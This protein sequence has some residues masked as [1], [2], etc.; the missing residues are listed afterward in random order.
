MR[1][2]HLFEFNFSNPNTHYSYA[3]L[4]PKYSKLQTA[5]DKGRNCGAAFLGTDTA[6]LHA[7]F[8]CLLPRG[9]QER[10]AAVS[11]LFYGQLS[12][13]VLVLIIVISTVLAFSSLYVGGAVVVKVRTDRLVEEERRRMVRIEPAQPA[14][15]PP[16][17]YMQSVA[18]AT[19]L[20]ERYCDYFKFFNLCL[21]IQ[22][23]HFFPG[24]NAEF[25]LISADHRLRNVA[26]AHH[27]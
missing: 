21:F 12:T 10:R 19:T 6:A 24:N 25:L 22:K 4:S 26:K 3:L 9:S 13:L 16:P 18:P 8:G 15:V 23:K 2:F 27:A 1:N 14:P 20:S 5:V 7:G 11:P 17:Q